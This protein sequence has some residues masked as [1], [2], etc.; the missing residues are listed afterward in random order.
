MPLIKKLF[1]LVGELGPYQVDLSQDPSSLECNIY[2]KKKIFILSS[3][4]SRSLSVFSSQGTSPR[5]DHYSIRHEI[6]EEALLRTIQDIDL[7]FNQVCLLIKCNYALMLQML[8]NY[9][10]VIFLSPGSSWKRICFWVYC[11]YCSF[12]RWPI[13]DC[14]YRW[15]KGTVVLWT[16]SSPLSYRKSV[17]FLLV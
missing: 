14:Q 1:Y 11:N 2:D 13:F 15:F 7:E 6:L 3:I 5:S 9:S 16:K 17:T 10:S 12:S 8:K 4:L